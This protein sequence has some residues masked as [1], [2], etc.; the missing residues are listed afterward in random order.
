MTLEEFLQ[1]YGGNACVSIEGYCE[2]ACYDFYK[3]IRDERQYYIGDDLTCI[4]DAS[5]WDE[6]KDKEVTHWNIIRCGIYKLELCIRLKE[7]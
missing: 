6:V 2:E 5:W 1:N 7:D 4:A 3:D